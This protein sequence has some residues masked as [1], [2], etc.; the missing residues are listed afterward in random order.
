[1]KRPA[2][3]AIGALLAA[4]LLALL[5]VGALACAALS[6]FLHTGELGDKEKFAALQSVESRYRDY[7]QRDSILVIEHLDGIDEVALGLPTLQAGHP[8]AWALINELDSQGQLFMSPRDAQLASHCDQLRGVFK[9]HEPA[10][11]VAALLERVMD[12]K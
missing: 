2:V 12:C 10:A 3:F 8:R 4:T 5:I 6:F 11:E 7:G 1:M 9:T